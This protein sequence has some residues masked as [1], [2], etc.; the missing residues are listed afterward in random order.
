MLHNYIIV[1]NFWLPMTLLKYL[2]I[3][4][5]AGVGYNKRKKNKERK[6]KQWAWPG[7]HLVNVIWGYR[8]LD[9]EVEEWL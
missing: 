6:I 2:S 3:M 1:E 8:I 9:R 5:V 4:Q 7:P